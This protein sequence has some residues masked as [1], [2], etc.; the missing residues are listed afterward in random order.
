MA[1]AKKAAILDGTDITEQEV[2]V[3]EFGGAVLVR[4]LPAEYT[5]QAA[6]QAQRVTLVDG[7][8]VVTVDTAVMERL[9]FQHGVVEPDFNEKETREVFKKY[10]RAIKRVIEVIDEIS[11]VDKEAIEEAQR[12]FRAG[13]DGDVPD[14]GDADGVPVPA[15]GAPGD[16]G[17]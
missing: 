10:G 6:S 8:P 1:R 12:R 4:S 14:G 3:P 9:Q 5:N 11:G 7:N 13:G 16:D 2:D 17:D 15:S